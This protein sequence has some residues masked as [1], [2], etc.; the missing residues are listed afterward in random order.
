M[1]NRWYPQRLLA[2]LCLV[3][4][5]QYIYDQCLLIASGCQ[6]RC[7]DTGNLTAKVSAPRDAKDIDDSQTC[8]APDSNLYSW[9][10]YQVL[11]DLTS[12]IHCDSTLATVFVTLC[13]VTQSCQKPS[14]H[15]L[16][17]YLQAL[18]PT[19]NSSFPPSC[20]CPSCPF[21]T[22]IH[23]LRPFYCL[24]PLLPKLGSTPTSDTSFR[25]TV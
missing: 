24:E 6:G 22:Q 16:F 21:S 1:Q 15:F 20:L 2:P 19:Q 18:H 5:T 12:A 4:K 13:P 7:I 23:F 10:T 17:P 9:R 3:I 14:Q 25:I 8:D 11:H